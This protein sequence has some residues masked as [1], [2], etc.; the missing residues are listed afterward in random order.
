METKK[1]EIFFKLLLHILI[2]FTLLSGLFW[3]IIS[4]IQTE[5][6]TTAISNSLISAISNYKKTLPSSQEGLSFFKIPDD[7]KN[8]IIAS[9]STPDEKM[10]M[11][12]EYVKKMCYI[13]IIMF[14][15]IIL[16]FLGTLYF[17]C[18]YKDFPLCFNLTENI[19]I[20]TFVAVLEAVFFYKIALKYAPI[21]PSDIN[22]IILSELNKLLI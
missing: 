1:T 19:I 16:T 7:V 14:I 22:K 10:S 4:K 8:A 18:E 5:M 3:I 12:N 6:I 9:Y 17:S 11:N 15:L 2:L 20:F 21:L 13:Y